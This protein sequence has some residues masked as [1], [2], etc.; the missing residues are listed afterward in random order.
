M[1]LDRPGRYDSRSRRVDQRPVCTGSSGAEAITEIAARDRKAWG[2]YPIGREGGFVSGQL[3]ASF[4]VKISDSNPFSP[5]SANSARKRRRGLRPVDRASQGYSAPRFCISVS[6]FIRRAVHT[7][8]HF[9]C[10]TWRGYECEMVG[11]K[12][13]RA[14]QHVTNPSPPRK[15][16][17]AIVGRSG[18]VASTF[19]LSRQ[20]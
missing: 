10:P 19:G 4:L 3:Y 17:A 11:A 5:Q 8:R 9:E 1:G 2:T 12:N 20:T 6:C 13:P 15:R 14:E 18:L 16:A 7:K